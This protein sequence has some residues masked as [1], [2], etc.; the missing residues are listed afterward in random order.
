MYKIYKKLGLI[1]L[2]AGVLAFSSC[3]LET[4]KNGDLDG[5]WH[6]ESIDSLDNG[7]SADLSKLHVFWGVEHK[8]IAARETDFNYGRYYFRF[9]QTSDSLKITKVYRDH[10]H[11]DNGDDGGDIPQ[12]E[13]ND[14]LRYF[15]INEIPE[16]FLKEALD[17]S[18]MILKSKTLRLKFKKF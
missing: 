3:D 18:K 12:S 5:F 8:L 6:L 10:W 16:G 9:D 13:V 1:G 15:G 14:S 11:Q 4:S 2:M 17:G 7:H